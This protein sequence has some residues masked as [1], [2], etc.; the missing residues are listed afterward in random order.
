MPNGGKIITKWNAQLAVE[1]VIKNWNDLSPAALE[2]FLKDNFDKSW[3]KFDMYDR[4]SI[5]DTEELYFAR[6]LMNALAPPEK[7]DPYALDFSEKKMKQIQVDPL[8]E[9]DYPVMER[10]IDHT[11]TKTYKRNWES[12]A[13][14]T[15]NS[16]QPVAAS[17]DSSS[18]STTPAASANATAPATAPAAVPATAP[19]TAP[20]ATPAAPK[21][22][23]A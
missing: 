9:P 22:S 13:A 18:N 11:K 20:A 5:P 1:D 2:K 16:A 4:G 10:P 15:T 21:G 14:A 7:E 3:K 23:A 6:D 12:P 19:A 17:S 8:V